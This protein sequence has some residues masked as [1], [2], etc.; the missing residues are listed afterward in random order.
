MHAASCPSSYRSASSMND[1]RYR[2]GGTTGGKWGCALAAVVGLPLLGLAI[3]V[4]ALGDC[5]PEVPCNHDL[6]WSLILG[7]LVIS[8]AVG[9]AIRAL[10][11]RFVERG[12][13][14]S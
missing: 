14:D 11:N 5:I 3:L 13:G 8:L 12:A 7:A 4:S 1:E 9:V 10:I 2:G 6:E